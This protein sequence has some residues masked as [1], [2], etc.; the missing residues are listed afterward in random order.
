MPLDADKQDDEPLDLEWLQLVLLARH[1]GLTI[2]DV[3][4]FLNQHQFE[5]QG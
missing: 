5:L 1:A 4:V 2:D 3:R